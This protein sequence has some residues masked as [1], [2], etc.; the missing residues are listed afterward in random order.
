MKNK[1]ILVIFVV[2]AILVIVGALFKIMHWPGANPVLF[3]GMIGQVIAGVL[4]VFK[5]VT[6]KNEKSFL[7]S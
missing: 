7:N 1:H 2:A 6:N 5:L 4:T 3:V